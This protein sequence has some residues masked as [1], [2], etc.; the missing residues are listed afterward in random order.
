MKLCKFV[1]AYEQSLKALN[2][3][4]IA[5]DERIARI[6]VKCD[7]KPESR[8]SSKLAFY[9]HQREGLIHKHRG[10][11]SWIGTVAHPIFSVIG[12]RLGAAYQGIFCQDSD[13]HASMRFLHF[14]LGADCSLVLKMTMTRLCTEPSKEFVDLQIRRSVVT[15]FAGRS[16][17][18][19]PLETSICDVLTPLQMV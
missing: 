5:L 3:E 12:K 13:S 10:A 11:A 7:A 6:E 4:A 17:D 8:L 9:R 18:D 19:L 16:D 15:P 1:S 2:Q 14:R